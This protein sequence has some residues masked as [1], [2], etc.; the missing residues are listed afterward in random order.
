MELEGVL[1]SLF[2][3]L[4]S[5]QRSK[6]WRTELGVIY[7]RE[8]WFSW[9]LSRCWCADVMVLPALHDM[10][11][12]PL[13]MVLCVQ[14]YTC[15]KTIYYV[16]SL[17]CFTSDIQRPWTSVICV[18]SVIPFSWKPSY[19]RV[20][21]LTSVWSSGSARGGHLCN[22]TTT[23]FLPV[24]FICERLNTRFYFLLIAKIHFS[25]YLNELIRETRKTFLYLVIYQWNL[26]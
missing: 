20:T 14:S 5:C 21:F 10:W 4:C 1:C 18:Y 2:F 25:W 13:D 22:E 16:I 3:V 17:P 11:P 24:S 12:K 15:G 8:G 19:M 9:W 23:G 6:K 7:L 26:N